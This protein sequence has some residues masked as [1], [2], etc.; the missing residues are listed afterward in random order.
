MDYSP[1]HN[2]IKS[3]ILVEKLLLK[4]NPLDYQAYIETFRESM[5]DANPHQIEAVVYALEKLE[6]GGGCILADEV[7]LGKTIEA[8]LVISQFRARRRFNILVIVPTSLAGQWNNE[9][10]TLFQVPSRMIDSKTV[11]KLKNDHLDTLFAEPGVYIMGRELASR[12]AKQRTLCNT[13]WDLVVVDEAHEVFANIYKRFNSRDGSY[14]EDSKQ[15]LT[16]AHLYRLFKRTPL[17]LLTATPI[18]NDILELWGLAAYILPENKNHLGRLNHFK[19][20]FLNKGQLVEDKLPELRQ[21]VGNFLVRNLRHNAQAFMDYKFTHRNCQ[22]LNFN[23]DN[24]EKQLYR[25]IS[26]YLE[27]DDIYAYGNRGMVEI[28]TDKS[29]GIRTLLKMSYRRALGSSFPALQNTLEKLAHRL[30]TMRSGEKPDLSGEI[31]SDDESNDEEDRLAVGLENG[32]EPAFHMPLDAGG[33]PGLDDEIAEVRGYIRRARDISETA[34]DTIIV[35]TLRK[36]FADPDRFYPKA[37]IFTS[38]IGTQKHLRAILESNGFAGEVVLFSGSGKRSPEERDEIKRIVDVWENEVGYTIPAVEKPGGAI[39]ERTAIVHYFKTRKQIL[40]ST[41]AGAKGLNLQFCNILI[42]YDLPWNPQRIEQRIGRCHRYSQ[43]KDVMVINCINEDNETEKRVY[44]ILENKFSLFKSVLGAGDAILGG[45][46]SAFHFETKIND[47]LNNFKTPEE[48][49]VW[50]RRFEEEIDEETRKLRDRK[51]TKARQLLDELD[52]NVTDKLR[53]IK[54]QL[55]QSFSQYDADLLALLR[56]YAAFANQPFQ[57]LD[58]KNEHILLRYNERPYYIGRRDDE[59]MR[60]FTHINLKDSVI[61][62]M[63]RSIREQTPPNGDTIVFHY[64]DQPKQAAVL[65]PHTGKSGRWDFYSVNFQGL[66]EEERLYHIVALDE[67]NTF[68]LLIDDEINALLALPISNGS[69]R[70]V[71]IEEADMRERLEEKT[72]ADE[73]VIQNQQQARI[74]RKLQNLKVELQDMKEYLDKKEAELTAKIKELDQ[75]IRNTNDRKEGKQLLEE[76]ARLDK[77]ARNTRTKKLEFEN[78]FAEDFTRQEIAL[79]G[80]RFLDVEPR[81]IFSLCFEIR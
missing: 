4:R 29:A 1:I 3:R 31:S 13:E 81:L 60:D 20:L 18:Q 47:I 77:E 9:L 59:K 36:L 33:M 72:D 78:E 42:N 67:G 80:K 63:I 12:L 25:D 54:Q 38:Y 43:E 58:G 79:Q 49:D 32:D 57:K 71:E 21:R 17:L 48:R 37:V 7:G 24:E 30:E 8:G 65:E 39:L 52:P 19:D 44:Q 70:S 68:S 35:E 73:A 5:I 53:N 45:L 26:T 66:E 62:D 74:D 27:R 11:R 23:M 40:I 56:H 75:K 15:N 50:L 28:G 34:K 55:P 2:L 69:S 76:K 51:L 22:T 14:Q 64:N 10:R 46:S 16:A 61:V 6:G 41:E